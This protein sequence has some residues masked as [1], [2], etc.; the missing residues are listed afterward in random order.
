MLTEYIQA[1]MRRATYEMI[2]DCSFWGEISELEGLWAHAATLDA[3]KG[4][5]QSA[6]EDWIVF[7]LANRFPL[8]ALDGIEL[9]ATKVA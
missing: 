1:A 4:E 6:L 7:S 9:A 2:E 8:P 3:C 5:L